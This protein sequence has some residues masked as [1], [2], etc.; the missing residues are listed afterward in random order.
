MMAVS[1]AHNVC[2]AAREFSIP[3][4]VCALTH[5]FTPIIATANDQVG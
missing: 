4:I 5:K 1:G 2:L 3:V